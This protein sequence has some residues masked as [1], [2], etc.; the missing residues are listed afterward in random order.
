MGGSK[1][2]FGWQ[3]RNVNVGLRQAPRNNIKYVNKILRLKKKE[4]LVRKSCIS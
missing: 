3:N 4:L 2:E 1:I